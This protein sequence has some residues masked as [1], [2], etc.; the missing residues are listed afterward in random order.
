MSGR[1]FLFSQPSSDGCRTSPL[2]RFSK[3]RP[4]ARPGFFVDGPLGPADSRCVDFE[5]SA[6]FPPCGT[7]SVLLEF[8][9]ETTAPVA[10]LFLSLFAPRK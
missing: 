8:F 5:N 10:R 4:H 2:N 3:T 1:R 7:V 9:I 6:T